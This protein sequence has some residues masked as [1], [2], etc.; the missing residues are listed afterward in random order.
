MPIGSDRGADVLWA[1]AV[2]GDRDAFAVVTVQHRHELAMHCYRMLGSVEDA[3]DVVQETL[4][5]AWRKRETYQGRSTVRAWLYGIAPNAC[6]DVLD[7]RSRRLMPPALA[8]AA[9]PRS[10]L[11]PASDVG[12]LEPYP[13]VLLDKA[14]DPDA[15]P[16][17]VAVARET[18]ELAFLV[19]IQHLPPRQRAVLILRDVLGWKA[20][21]R[22]LRCR[23]ERGRCQQCV[24][25]CPFDT[26]AAPSRPSP[27]LG[28]VANAGR[29][30][31][32][33]SRA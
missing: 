3:E 32:S 8:P 17:E 4:L 33:A 14:D 5:R 7:G 13:D 15:R 16:D 22:R 9:D 21:G 27:G 18:I 28:P 2:A 12:W 23:D 20:L 1:A 25:A 26:Q 19:A 31:H 30:P 11:P 6:L 10:T 29:S 24:A